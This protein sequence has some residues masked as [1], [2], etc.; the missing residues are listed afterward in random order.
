MPLNQAASSTAHTQ[1]LGQGPPVSEAPGGTP[2]NGVTVRFLQD[3]PE[4]ASFAAKLTV[5]A[6][7]NKFA[8]NITEEK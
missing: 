7:R 6:F 1:P 4:D 3:T 8:T 2:V 5:E